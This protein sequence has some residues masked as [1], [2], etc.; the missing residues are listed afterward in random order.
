[1][2]VASLYVGLYVRM[3][4]IGPICMHACVH[5]L[6]RYI[7]SQSYVIAVCVCAIQVY[8]GLCMYVCM[9]ACMGAFL[10]LRLL[11]LAVLES[12]APLNSFIEEALYK[13]LI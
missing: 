11:F 4:S 8:V 7:S 5:V 1:M 10:T 3:Y 13:C 9:H 12:G 6:C 2:C